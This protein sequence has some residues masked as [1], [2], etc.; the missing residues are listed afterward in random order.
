MPVRTSESPLTC[1][2]CRQPMQPQDFE[3]NDHGQVRVDLC[4]TCQGI[5]FDHLESAQLAPS[6][7]IELF[8]EIHAHK[9]DPRQPLASQMTC[10]RCSEHLVLSFDLSKAGRFSYFRCPRGD[11]RFTTFFQF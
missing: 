9:D 2:S 8:K 4:F 1:S 6:A 11:G 3:R 5:W 10:P 7:V